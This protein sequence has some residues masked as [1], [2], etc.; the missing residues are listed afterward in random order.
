RC[1][2]MGLLR[3]VALAV[4][5]IAAQAAAITAPV[6]PAQKAEFLGLLPDLP[7]DGEFFTHAGVT[8]GARYI[9]VLFALTPQDV[10][11]DHLYHVLALSRGLCDRS[12]YRRYGVEH[13]A[14]IGHPTVKAFWA[15]VLRTFPL[16]L[17][18]VLA[19]GPV[20]AAGPSRPI[21]TDAFDVYLRQFAKGVR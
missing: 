19:I 8:Q 10:D 2:E 11:T 18:A 17:G 7:H 1:L 4:A 9:Q 20:L 21:Q 6:S 14:E 15:A 3:N 12:K 5:L 16:L 13:F